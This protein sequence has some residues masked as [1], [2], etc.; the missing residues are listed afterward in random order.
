MEVAYTVAN[1][2][3]ILVINEKSGSGVANV[4]E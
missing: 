4:K 2:L 1:P 3:F